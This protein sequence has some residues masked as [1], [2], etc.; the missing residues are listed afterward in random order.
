MKT[1][2]THILCELSGCTEELLNHHVLVGKFMT[3]AALRAGATIVHDFFH[4]FSPQGVS[5]VLVLAESHFSIHT[6]P[7]Q[8]YAALDFYTCGLMQPE[9]A[10]EYMSVA[11]GSSHRQILRV[12]RGICHATHYAMERAA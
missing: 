6:W 8:R 10:C 1:I 3:E 2:G 5:G 9:L 7:E 12:N 4:Q 11:L